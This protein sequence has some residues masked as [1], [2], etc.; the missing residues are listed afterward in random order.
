MSRSFSLLTN[1][2]F[3]LKELNVQSWI[4]EPRQPVADWMMGVVI[5]TQHIA[6]NCL[7]GMQMA[8][9]SLW[10]FNTVQWAIFI[11]YG[12]DVHGSGLTKLAETA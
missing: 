7:V 2:S 10:A 5:M 9:V 8:V 1:A 4:V 11:W 12:K 6:I 3:N